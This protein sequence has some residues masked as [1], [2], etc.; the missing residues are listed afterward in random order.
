M[1]WIE[2]DF[3]KIESSFICSKTSRTDVITLNGTYWLLSYWIARLNLF[4]TIHFTLYNVDTELGS[5]S[6][7]TSHRQFIIRS[8]RQK[9]AAPSFVLQRILEKTSIIISMVTELPVGRTAGSRQRPAVVFF[10]DSCNELIEGVA[11]ECK[12][13]PESLH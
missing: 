9:N 1:Y 10:A 4:F 7:R 2:L 3:L 6:N 12:L 8:L 11:A 13:L 5:R